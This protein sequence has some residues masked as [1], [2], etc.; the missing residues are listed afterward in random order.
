MEHVDAF[1]AHDTD[2]LLATVHPAVLWTTGTDVF[3]G[4]DRLRDEVFDDAFWA[5]WPSL[6]VQTLVVD[7]DS[8][9]AVLTER[10]TVDGEERS[11]DIA[12]FF[13]VALGVITSVRVLGA[14]SADL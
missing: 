5:L 1:N 11:Y 3:R 8:A 6:R 14:G 2:R 7:G 4:A 9:A 10:I 12:A 13:T